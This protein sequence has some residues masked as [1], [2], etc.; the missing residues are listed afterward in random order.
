[1]RCYKFEKGLGFLYILMTTLI[2][3]AITLMLIF[4]NNSYLLSYLLQSILIIFNIHQLYYLFLPKTLNLQI[5]GKVIIINML[6]GF[7]KIIIPFKSIIEIEKRNLNVKGIKLSGFSGKS[8][9]FGRLYYENIGTIRMF[10]TDSKKTI[11]LKTVKENIAISPS[12]YEEIIGIISKKLKNKVADEKKPANICLCKDKYFIIPFIIS[13]ILILIYMIRPSMMYISG[14]LNNL[15]LPIAFNSDFVPVKY[16]TAKDFIF[17]QLLYGALNMIIMVC[18]YF[19]EYLYSK[20]DRKASYKYMF[21]SMFVI[22]IFF[23]LQVRI[24]HTYT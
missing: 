8:Y 10:V 21:I 17:N 6:F 5:G 4:V 20:Y 7:R 15:K 19:A 24:I 18:M 22:I 23:I 11:I 13:T 3:N 16:G 9:S 12:D 2:F 1:M 14:E